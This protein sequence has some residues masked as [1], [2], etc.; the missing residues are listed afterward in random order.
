VSLHCL[1]DQVHTESQNLHHFD[2]PQIIANIRAHVQPPLAPNPWKF[3]RTTQA[4]AH[5]SRLLQLHHFDTESATQSLPNTTLSYGSEFKPASILE[6]LL[7]HHQHWPAF[8]AI[9][10]EGVSYPLTPLLEAD[11][12][13]D[14]EALTEQG[15][16]KSTQTPDNMK[17]LNKAFD[18]EVRYEW[19]IP[20]NPNCIKNIKGASVTPLGVA[21]QWSIDS[22]GNRIIKRRTTH[23]CT[24][25]GPSRA[26]CNNRVITDLLDD[27][28]YS[29]TLRRFLHG[30]HDIRQRHPDKVIWINKTDMDAA[31]CRLHTNM[32][33]AITCITIIDSIAYLLLRVPF[34]AS[35]APTKFSSISNTAADI[36]Q[37]LAMDPRW[38]PAHLHSSF[39]LDLMTPDPPPTAKIGQADPLLVKL[40]PRD[41]VTDSF[42][43][44][45][46]QACVD[47]GN[48]DECI[49]HTI[50]LVLET[51]FRVK[52]PHHP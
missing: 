28:M 8:K 15:N 12:L 50:P 7:K 49:R 51:I 32:S 4:A 23:D 31:Y 10:E 22:Q 20:I 26:S 43:N 35:P 25:P 45:L 19:A 11:R 13:R 40:P 2:L 47:V 33:A 39:D 21:V 34:G 6:P 37:D 38:D 48:N 30:I 17:A 42:I 14:L 52:D 41:I 16:H 44:D 18:K 46:F 1:E 27:C 5:N 29:H 9:V 3:E 24:F 36:A